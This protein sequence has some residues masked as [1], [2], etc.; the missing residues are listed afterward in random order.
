VQQN[1][2]LFLFLYQFGFIRLPLLA[3][4][5][6]SSAYFHIHL[7]CCFLAVAVCFLLR[8]G[9][10][11]LEKLTVDMYLFELQNLAKASLE[12]KSEYLGFLMPFGIVI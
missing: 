4:S 3:S 8:I 12:Y 6:A 9:I 7:W 5:S 2:L 11:L 1:L 10:N